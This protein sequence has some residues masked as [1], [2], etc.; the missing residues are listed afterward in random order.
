[1]NFVQIVGRLSSFPKKIN[2]ATCVFDSSMTMKV[3]KNFQVGGAQNQADEF[4]VLLWRGISTSI[5]EGC[6]IGQLIAVKGRLERRDDDIIVI[7]EF[8]QP[9]QA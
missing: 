5:L 4:P 3:D 9:L 2:D 1:M 8:V 6:K 7:A